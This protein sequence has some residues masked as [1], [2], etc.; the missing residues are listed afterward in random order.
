MQGGGFGELDLAFVS[1]RRVPFLHVEVE[2]TRSAAVVLAVG[3]VLSGAMVL[4]CSP[5][6]RGSGDGG[7]EAA[8]RKTATE[9]MAQHASVWITLRSGDSARGEIG[10]VDEN[11]MVLVE[12]SADGGQSLERTLA[13]PDVRSVDVE[14]PLGNPTRLLVLGLLFGVLAAFAA[15]GRGVSSL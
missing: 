3:L 13:W 5:L 9:A 10:G 2:M 14:K 7:G 11:G 12:A 6:G 1:W 8:L 15:V 4:G